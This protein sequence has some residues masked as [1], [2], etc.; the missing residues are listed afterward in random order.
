MTSPPPTS[1]K[2]TDAPACAWTLKQELTRRGQR[3][4][5]IRCREVR[6]TSIDHER[7]HLQ[8][9]VY[10]SAGGHEHF[11]SLVTEEDRLAAYLR[12]WMPG[13]DSPDAGLEDLEGAARVR[14]LHVYGPSLAIG[15]VS[16][17]AA[18][19]AGLGARLMCR[20][21]EIAS[22]AGAR[23]VAVIAAL[24]TRLYYERLGYT[25]GE[26]YMVREL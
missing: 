9:D 8:S 4:Q 12:L 22:R 2:E 1:W 19:H 24:G 21:E 17:G 6:G 15:D 3:C 23:R 25:L 11:L 20:A 13:P 16:D 10:A 14:E 7:L 18:Q 5:C 26:T